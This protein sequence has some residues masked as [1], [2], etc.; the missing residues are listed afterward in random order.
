MRSNTKNTY[1]PKVTGGG[2]LAMRIT[3]YKELRR[4]TLAALLFEDVAYESGSSQAKRIAELITEC[5]PTQVASL[6]IECRNSMYLRH[7]PLFLVRELARTKGNGPLV[8]STLDAVIQRPDELTEYLAIYFRDNPDQPLSKGSKV[9]LDR[10]FRK[11]TAYDLGKYDQDKA[12]K[13]RDVLRLVHAKPSSFDQGLLWG[14]VIKREVPTPDTWEVALSAGVD[15][16]TTWER[17]L[18]EK[19]LGGLAF[20]RNLRNMLEVDVDLDLIRE[21]FKGPFKKVLPFRFV[22]A[23]THALRLEAEIEAAMLRAAGDLP[24]L[25]GHTVFVVDVSGSMSSKVSLKS[26]M[27]RLGA[28][29]ALAVLAREQCEST[30]I[31]LTAGN[32]STRIH[33]TGLA[34]ARHGMAL[35]DEITKGRH[36]LG[37]GGIFLVDCLDWV[38]DDLHHKAPDR[39]I[40]LTDEQDCSGRGFKPED[41]HPFGRFNYLINVSVNKNGIGYGSKWTHVDG[42]SER[43]L[44]FILEDETD[45]LQ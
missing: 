23:A 15:K 12:F 24:K 41:A 32:D 42:W 6:A 17:L 5:A 36:D 43:V 30:D 37:G 3:P 33:K 44:D 11:F 16:K 13:L 45:T 18:R 39:L 40:V 10:A 31:Y 21:R 27:T 28:A 19:K 26:E 25:K 29:G 7:M 22:S 2:G 38:W 20:L 35:V 1:T 8:A 4:M 34:R 14:Q 9:G